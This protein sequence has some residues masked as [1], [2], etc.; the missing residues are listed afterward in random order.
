[1]ILG[2]KTNSTQ[3]DFIS[4]TICVCMLQHIYKQKEKV[5]ESVI[6]GYQSRKIQFCSIF[7]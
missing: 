2:E 7:I 4:I 3:R 1:M 6:S 5:M